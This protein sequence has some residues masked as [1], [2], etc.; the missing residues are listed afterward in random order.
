MAAAPALSI[1]AV[2]TRQPNTRGSALSSRDDEVADSQLEDVHEEL[3]VL[4]CGGH[5]VLPAG[6]DV[7]TFFH[8]ARRAHEDGQISIHGALVVI[9][10]TVPETVTQSAVGSTI[11][12]VGPAE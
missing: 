1:Q 12:A 6:F 4:R 8:R 9:P 10:V 11:G 3:G 5:R 7:E 2:Q